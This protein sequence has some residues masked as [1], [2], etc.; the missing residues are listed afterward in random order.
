LT[1]EIALDKGWYHF[2]LEI[3]W[4][5][6]LHCMYLFF[7]MYFKVTHIFREEYSCVDKMVTLVYLQITSLG[8]ITCL[9]LFRMVL[10][11]ID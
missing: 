9:T 8:E 4:Q 5:F 11:A 7:K 1:I 10:I 3:N 6:L 2:W